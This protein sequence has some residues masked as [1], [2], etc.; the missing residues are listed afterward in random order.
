MSPEMHR[1]SFG[2]FEKRAADSHTD[3]VSSFKQKTV[4]DQSDPALKGCQ[5]WSCATLSVCQNHRVIFAD[6]K[7]KEIASTLRKVGQTWVKV[8]LQGGK[9]LIEDNT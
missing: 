1:K 7:V 6:W 5:G 9:E 2:T 8:A 4:S 3:G